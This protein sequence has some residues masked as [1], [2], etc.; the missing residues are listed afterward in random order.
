MI[1]L[2]TQIFL[3]FCCVAS[4]FVHAE[5]PLS[6]KG[7]ASVWINTPFYPDLALWSGIRYIPTLHFATHAGAGLRPVPFNLINNQ[8]IYLPSFGVGCAY[9]VLIVKLLLSILKC[10]NSN[11]T[12]LRLTRAV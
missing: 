7:Q 8:N 6:T 4:V 1:R 2:R 5:N 10:N 12:T 3:L 11:A 9:V